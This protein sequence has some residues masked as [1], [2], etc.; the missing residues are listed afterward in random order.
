MHFNSYA[1]AAAAWRA[2]K[3][4]FEQR[5]IH[6]DDVKAYAFDALMQDY[7][8]AFDALPTLS[9]D[10]NSAIPTMLSTFIDPQRYQILFAPLKAAVI[11]GE[12]QKGDWTQQTA[13]FPIS[14]NTGEVASYGDF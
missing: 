12:A 5:G 9:T 3:P 11:Y 6:L 14:E 2:H 13:M 10:P 7:T 4:M 8:L 1:E